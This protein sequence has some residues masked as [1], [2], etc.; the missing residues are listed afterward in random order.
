MQGKGFRING[1]S[2]LTLNGAADCQVT[3]Y[4]A[5]NFQGEQRTYYK[6]EF[7]DGECKDVWSDRA[8]SI[9][10]SRGPPPGVCSRATWSHLMLL[11]S[12]DP[13][14]RC[15]SIYSSQRMYLV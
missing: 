10:V 2:S 1:V 8:D 5:D 12:W 11:A 9:K 4:D 13:R 7:P 15:S 6:R 14:S 3:L